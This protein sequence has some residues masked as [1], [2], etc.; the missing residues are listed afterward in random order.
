MREP[1]KRQDE[2][3]HT[4]LPVQQETAGSSHNAGATAGTA[5]AADTAPAD[6]QPGQQGAAAPD[7][8]ER[9]EPPS[10][11]DAGSDAAAPDGPGTL[12]AAVRR[13][14]DSDT[15]LQ[16]VKAPA[17]VSTPAAPGQ[18][19]PLPEAPRFDFKRA[20]RKPKTP[21]PAA[22]ASTQGLSGSK[23]SAAQD[24]A[25][26]SAAAGAE[27]QAAPAGAAGISDSRTAPTTQQTA[28]AAKA[29]LPPPA[30]SASSFA[31]TTGGSSPARTAA[32]QSAQAGA[33]GAEPAAAVAEA[34]AGEAAAA[35][36]AQ[37]RKA[38]ASPPASEPAEAVPAAPTTASPDL[39]VEAAAA[40]PAAA[41]A[42][43]EVDSASMPPGSSPT[44]TL[45]LAAASPSPPPP[46]PQ[47]SP[48]LSLKSLGAGKEPEAEVAAPTSPAAMS[49]GP[50][51][52]GTASEQP[53][54]P[55]ASSEGLSRQ[56]SALA[57]RIAA[58]KSQDNGGISSPQTPATAA[59]VLLSGL[60]SLRNVRSGPAEFDLVLCVVLSHAHIDRRWE[61]QRETCQGCRCGRTARSAEGDIAVTPAIGKAQVTPGSVKERAD[62]IKRSSFTRTPASSPPP[63]PQFKWRVNSQGTTA[64]GASN[65]PPA[66][67]EPAAAPR[68]LAQRG[69]LT[70]ATITFRV[71]CA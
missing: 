35:A 27:P 49:P 47:S 30:V 7:G 25:T 13:A 11:L 38:S 39:G 55:S 51:A 43:P 56:T 28:A 60:P 48:Q 20:P 67:G 66:V 23:G 42:A 14:V 33:A 54:T 57:A 15:A 24:E 41:A 45:S 59:Q 37:E 46:P 62:S 61:T 53:S 44:A 63:S 4:S 16:A 69:L 64:R 52:A 8:T 10:P 50:P 21:G 58:L 6:V 70:S 40:Q 36:T 65:G 31:D 17:A 34:A 22:A 3:S 32:P 71:T 68:R 9:T 12:P 2:A 5:P 26:S 19:A 1:Q 29:T 18:V